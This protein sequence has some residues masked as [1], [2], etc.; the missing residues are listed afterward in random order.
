MTHC[1][2]SRSHSLVDAKLIFA[3]ILLM[4]LAAS[5]NAQQGFAGVCEGPDAAVEGVLDAIAVHTQDPSRVFIAGA[6]GIYRSCDGGETWLAPQPFIDSGRGLLVKPTD[7]DTV[8]YGTRAHGLHR[9]TDGGVRFSRIGSEIA[10]GAVDAISIDASGGIFALSEAGLYRSKDG[11]TSWALVDGVPSGARSYGLVTDPQNINNIYLTREGR[12]VYR[13]NDGGVTWSLSADGLQNLQLFDLDLHPT[14]SAMLFATTWRGVHLS[15]DAGTTWQRVGTFSTAMNLAIDPAHP[16]RIYAVTHQQGI[17]KSIDGGQTWSAANGALGAELPKFVG[18]AISPTGR[19]FAGTELQGLYVSD[20]AAASWRLIGQP[21]QGT[22]APTQPPP[23][24]SP[25]TSVPQ[26]GDGYADLRVA[27]EY[28]G[29]GDSIPAGKK[30]KFRITITNNGPDMSQNTTLSIAWFRS[31]IVGAPVSYNI[32]SNSSQ[33]SCSSAKFC[34]LGSIANG[35]QVTIDV[36]AETQV[37]TL[38]M[39]NLTAAVN[40]SQISGTQSTLRIGSSVTVFETGGGGGVAGLPTL[41][42]P[43]MLLFIRRR[44]MVARTS[45]LD[46]VRPQPVCRGS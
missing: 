1:K 44:R 30:G 26:P 5:A 23:A 37:D 19:L 21:I 4:T 39:Y 22:P 43:G 33:G 32:T 46:R 13:S 16:D 6:G 8:F 12:G 9:S 11:G 2:R 18:L 35:D 7:V 14:N 20:D 25:P 10:P 40:S 38:G 41:M 15:V 34:M 45:R 31:K 36:Q 24:N 42:L 28:R 27:L 29:K 17:H 3:G